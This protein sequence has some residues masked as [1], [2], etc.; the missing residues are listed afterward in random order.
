MASELTARSPFF[1]I[2]MTLDKLTS[3]IVN[4]VQSGLAGLN[5]NPTMSYEQIADE[6]LETREAL[7]KE[8][9]LK[10]FLRAN[11]LTQAINCVEVDCKDSNLCPCHELPAKNQLHF[12]IPQLV[13]VLG[14]NAVKFIGS[15]DR[16]KPFK[17]YYTRTG[18]EMHRY[19]PYNKNK[20]YVYLDTT[21]NANGKLDGW[22]FNAPL[23]T[24][25]SVVAVFKD[26]RALADYNCC[27]DPEQ[28]EDL[29][30]L[31]EEIKDRIVKKKIQMYRQFLMAPHQ[32]DL[33]P[34]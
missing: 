12:E 26:P 33:S 4:D 27:A 7:I 9:W 13:N 16:S 25:L 29:G 3:A 15:T 22:V 17:V 34:R 14:D 32:T 1:I 2:T 10:G 28:Y 5:A 11:E 6:V 30:S 8:H 19:K 18:A 24:N 20:P 23:I 31:S 21:P